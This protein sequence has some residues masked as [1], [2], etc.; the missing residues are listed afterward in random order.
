MHRWR[1]EVSDEYGDFMTLWAFLFLNLSGIL[2]FNQKLKLCFLKYTLSPTQHVVITWVI[3]LRHYT[4]SMGGSQDV[5]YYHDNIL[6]FIL[7]LFALDS[8][9]RFVF[10]DDD[11]H[12]NRCRTVTANLHNMAS[13]K[14]RAVPTEYVCHSVRRRPR[15]RQRPHRR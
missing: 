9:R 10:E 7:L 3:T 14:P 12:E 1:R 6:P 5:Q 4:S 11:T 8:G 13:S 15:R 2:N